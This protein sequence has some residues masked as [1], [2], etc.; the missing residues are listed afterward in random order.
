M[1]NQPAA[2]SHR[3]LAVGCGI[4]FFHT[5]SACYHVCEQSDSPYY[6]NNFQSFLSLKTKGVAP[7]TPRRRPCS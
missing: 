3:A 6:S 2:C 4:V 1:T 7:R 5:I